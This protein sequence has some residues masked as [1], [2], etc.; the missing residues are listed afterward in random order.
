[1]INARE[2]LADV[3]LQNPAG[4]GMIAADL[5][6]RPAEPVQ[7]SVRPLADATG[8]GVGNEQTVEDWIQDAMDGVVNQPITH[9]CLVNDTGLRVADGKSLILP[10]PVG[11]PGEIIM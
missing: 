2:K 1:M 3:A 9:R 7:R 6:C 5:P 8:K 11:Q 4:S 10:M